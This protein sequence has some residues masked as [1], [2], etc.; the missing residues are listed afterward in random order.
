MASEPAGP[1]APKSHGAADRDTRVGDELIEFGKVGRPHGVRGAVLVWPHNPESTLLSDLASVEVRTPGQK[2]R[3]LVFAARRRQPN[4]SWIVTFDGLTSR[5]HAEALNGSTVWIRVAE[6]PPLDEGEYY[7][8]SVIGASV[9]TP[10]GRELGR[11]T[12]VLETSTD[13]F[14]VNR[15]GRSA[16]YVPVVGDYVLSIDGAARRVTVVEDAE[17]L[18]DFEGD[19]D[20]PAGGDGEG[21]A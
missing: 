4:G 3:R 9:L 1:A 19:D 6:L 11:V 20:P 14:V 15:P 18:L 2:A 7:H 12:E 8:H 16:L 5:D 17:A 10:A 21:P 13:V